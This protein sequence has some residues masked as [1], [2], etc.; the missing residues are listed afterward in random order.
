[1]LYACSKSNISNVILEGLFK[2]QQRVF[3]SQS[4]SKLPI[5]YQS[6][7][8]CTLRKYVDIALDIPM[9]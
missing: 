6:H 5:S 8:V 7:T 1:V 4:E 2:M 9:D 3:E